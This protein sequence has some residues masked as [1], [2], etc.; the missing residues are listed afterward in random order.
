MMLT[1]EMQP[2]GLEETWELW[3][4]SEGDREQQK[5]AVAWW[6]DSR[7]G[8]CPQSTSAGVGGSTPWK[9]HNL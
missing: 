5:G 8:F 2:S 6:R 9:L 4:G 1:G 3:S 7:E